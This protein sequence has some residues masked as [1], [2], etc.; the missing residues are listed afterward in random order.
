MQDAR[1]NV[2]SLVPSLP[3]AQQLE[4]P[5]G[6]QKDMGSIPVGDSDVFFFPTLVTY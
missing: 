2:I 1:Q 3:E 6:L 4:R 5:T